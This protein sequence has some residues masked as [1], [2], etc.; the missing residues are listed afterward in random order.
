MNIFLMYLLFFLGIFITF[1]VITELFDCAVRKPKATRK[2]TRAVINK[3]G[4][5]GRKLLASRDNKKKKEDAP[6]SEKFN[7]VRESVESRY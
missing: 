2:Q 5:A 3:Y 6:P 4:K 1:C 7:K